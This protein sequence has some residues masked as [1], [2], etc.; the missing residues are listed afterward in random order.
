MKKN[1]FKAFT[2]VELLVVIAIIALLVSILMPSLS[3]ARQEARCVACKSNFKNL[4]L[5]LRMYLDDHKGKMPAAEPYPGKYG[6]VSQHWFMNPELMNYLAV[7][8]L[9]DEDGELLAPDTKNK[10]TVLTC[11]SHRYPEM[12]RDSPPDYP[13]QERTFA[14]SYAANGTWGVSGKCNMPT[15]YRHESEYRKPADSLMFCDASGSIQVPGIVLFDGCP[16]SNF[17]FRHHERV[18]MIFLDQHI[19]SFTEDEIPFC[20]RFDEERFGG[21]WYAKQK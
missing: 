1:Y 7:D 19:E 11:P 17:A 4:G 16:K 15:E 8:I 5:A 12:S 20:S 14:L 9:K 2:L 10:D 6:H 13:A 3:A 18:N 21:F